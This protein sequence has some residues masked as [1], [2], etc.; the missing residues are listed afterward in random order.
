MH[1]QV[2]LCR[3]VL[4]CPG[5]SY[6][7][8]QCTSAASESRRSIGDAELRCSIKLPETQLL[9]LR[10]RLSRTRILVC[11]Y[12]TPTHRGGLQCIQGFN[13]RFIQYHGVFS[14]L[15]H[16]AKITS[17]GFGVLLTRSLQQRAR[18]GNVQLAT[19]SHKIKISTSHA[20]LPHLYLL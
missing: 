16:R 9:S 17:L 18:S 2:A 13:S 15:H 20:S 7:R 4:C 11:M 8:L 14:A 6:R 3:E 1:V 12:Q 10:H 19:A 5:S